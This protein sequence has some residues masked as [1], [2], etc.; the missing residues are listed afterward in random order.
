M[1]FISLLTLCVNVIAAK[2]IACTMKVKEWNSS[3][4]DIDN[5]FYILGTYRPEI[6]NDKCQ[7]PLDVMS[8]FEW[9]AN[10]TIMDDCNLIC[11]LCLAQT[12][13]RKSSAIFGDDFNDFGII[14]DEQEQDDGDND[15]Q[16]NDEQHDYNE[17][18]GEEEHDDEYNYEF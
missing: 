4:W 10:G 3:N 7:C 15:E 16:D 1:K 13:I 6:L 14:N 18:Y 8:Q 9:M 2:S 12:Q 11:D 17:G 5:P